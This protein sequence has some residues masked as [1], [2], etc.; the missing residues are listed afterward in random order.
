MATFE[1]VAVSSEAEAGSVATLLSRL[2]RASSSAR[3][4]DSLARAVGCVDVDGEA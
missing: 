3:W 1:A 4:D 2:R